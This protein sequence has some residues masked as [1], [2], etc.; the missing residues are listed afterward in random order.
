MLPPDL[1]LVH[2][3]PGYLVRGAQRLPSVKSRVESMILV[4]YLKHAINYPI[5]PAKILEDLTVASS[6]ETFC[7]EME[8]FLGDACL[9][10]VVIICLF[11]KYRQGQLTCMR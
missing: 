3:F 2:P 1:C 8:E 6:Q 10:W 4:V 9:K 11:L 7:Y 5:P